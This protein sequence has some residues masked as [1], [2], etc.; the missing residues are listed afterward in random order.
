M[1]EK[2]DF[3]SPKHAKIFISL[4][5]LKLWFCYIYYIAKNKHIH[6]QVPVT[7]STGLL[8]HNTGTKATASLNSCE[9]ILSA[10]WLQLLWQELQHN[11]VA[12]EYPQGTLTNKRDW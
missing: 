1:T 4:N 11:A 2:F 6:I 7:S 5:M 8:Q 10:H 12:V 3:C 9:G